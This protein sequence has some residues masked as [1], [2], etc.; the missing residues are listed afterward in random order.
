MAV[1]ATIRNP[2]LHKGI[3]PDETFR[4]SRRGV[5]PAGTS[6]VRDIQDKQR[7]RARGTFQ[8]KG[9]G[10][11][12][13]AE[14]PCD[15]PPLPS[16]PSPVVVTEQGRGR[17]KATFSPSSTNPILQEHIEVEPPKVRATWRPSELL[18]ALNSRRDA[19]D[20]SPPRRRSQ[21]PSSIFQP[22]TEPTPVR[23]RACLER[24]T[25][26]GWL[27]QYT[28]ALPFRDQ[29]V[30]DKPC[31][32]LLQPADFASSVVRRN[33]AQLNRLRQQ[34]VTYT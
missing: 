20:S 24:P 7:G 29:G 5:A 13:L 11:F 33:Q 17:R 28:Y 3:E 32:R 27:L 23:H 14:P 25:Q 6:P 34:T 1:K 9:Q 22:A 31:Q 19:V 15:P 26:A 21:Q 8:L 30:T 10:T 16:R 2:I 4:P 18:S 12:T